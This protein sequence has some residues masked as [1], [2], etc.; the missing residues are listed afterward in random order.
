MSLTPGK[1]RVRAVA[2]KFGR[3]GTGTEQIAVDFEVAEGPYAGEHITW[4]GFFT[5]ATEERTLESLRYCGWQGDDLTDLSTLG[6][7][8]CEIDVGEETYEGNRQLKVK[9]VNRPGSGGVAM[10]DEMS[11]DELHSFAQRMKGRILAM[12]SA[13][14]GTP[15]P[16]AKAAPRPPAARPTPAPRAASKTPQGPHPNAPGSDAGPPPPDDRYF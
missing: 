9:W 3:A 14:P 5:D 4:Y 11:P 2:H 1:Y 15:R 10:K 6:S 12:G 8:E 7:E 16:A 13:K